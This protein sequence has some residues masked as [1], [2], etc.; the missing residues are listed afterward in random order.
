M[1]LFTENYMTLL[2]NERLREQQ[3]R[4]ERLAAPLPLHRQFTCRSGVQAAVAVTE[5]AL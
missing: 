2:D 4:A 5:M 3:L 1:A